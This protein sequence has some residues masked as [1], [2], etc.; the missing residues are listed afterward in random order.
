MAPALLLVGGVY[1]YPIAATLVYSVA[2]IDIGTYTI[3]SFVG[4][5][6]FTRVISS[7]AF[8]PT[9]LRT[10]YFGLLVVLIT[11][12]PAMFIALLL[13]EQ[14]RGRTF[15]RL[16]VLLPWAVPPVVGGVLW[17]QMF[18]SEFGFINRILGELGLPDDTIWLADPA[19]AL[20]SLAIAEAWR[21]IPFATLFLL[22]GLQTIPT[23]TY[24]AAQVDGAHARQRLWHITIPQL[25]PTIIP[26]IIFVFVWAM[27]T[28]DIIFVLTRGG[29]GGST[30]TMNYWVYEQGFET[31]QFGTA[32]AI[33]WLLTLVTILVI[34]ILV[35]INRLIFANKE[36]R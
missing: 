31:F 30:T 9:L 27:K 28:F 13:N 29:P 5:D 3:E 20:H 1:L 34:G 36:V 21:W 18:Q 14:F 19:L 24:E 11:L 17:G 10:L 2:T 33:A 32:A 26:V 22:A 12:V 25:M 7:S 35:L 8:I 23:N 16:V 6:N 4:L 15:V